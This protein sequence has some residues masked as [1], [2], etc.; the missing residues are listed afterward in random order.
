[1]VDDFSRTT[2]TYFLT[3]KKDASFVLKNFIQMVETQFQIRIK[4]IR[5]DNAFK[6][7]NSSDLQNYFSTK[8]IIHQTSCTYTPH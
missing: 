2:W 8:G 1:M 7:G 3:T 4:L 6:L 5:Y